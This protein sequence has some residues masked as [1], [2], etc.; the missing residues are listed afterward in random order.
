MEPVRPGQEGLRPVSVLCTDALVEL[1]V[2]VGPTE[3]NLDQK[4]DSFRQNFGATLLKPSSI[5]R[6]GG[7]T[8]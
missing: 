8:S 5:N 4:R 2:I 3:R 7:T 6:P 1:L